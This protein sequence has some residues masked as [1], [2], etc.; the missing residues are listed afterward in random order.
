MKPISLFCI[1]ILYAHTFKLNLNT[2][3]KNTPVYLI[4]FINK[5]K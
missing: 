2:I 4:S 1:V 3:L 5:S